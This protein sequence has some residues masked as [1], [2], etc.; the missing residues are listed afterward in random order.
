MDTLA[1]N[2]RYLLVY[3]HSYNQRGVESSHSVQGVTDTGRMVNVKLRVTDDDKSRFSKIPKVRELGRRDGKAGDS[4][5]AREDNDRGNR[6]GVVL[7]ARCTR[8]GESQG[9]TT[10]TAEWAHVISQHSDSHGPIAGIGRLSIS[11]KSGTQEVSAFFAIIYHLEHQVTVP[12]EQTDNLRFHLAKMLSSAME[13]GTS[14]GI[15]FRV[16]DKDGKVI[17]SLAR[18]FF[19]K[20]TT[21]TAESTQDA[22][23]STA[24]RF[25]DSISAE[26]DKHGDKQAVLTRLSRFSVSWQAFQH[27]MEDD[28]YNYIKTQYY[29]KDGTPKACR[30]V[31]RVK[32]ST[33]SGTVLLHRLHNMSDDGVPVPL[34]PSTLDTGSTLEPSVLYCSETSIELNPFSEPQRSAHRTSFATPDDDKAE[35]TAKGM[36]R[37]LEEQLKESGQWPF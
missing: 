11:K 8:E 3:P 35:R 10:Y 24:T 29:E 5:W 18:E 28:P 23:L 21:G 33:D 7:F 32:E 9:C 17:D 26:L 30:V 4:C 36:A 19:C 25:I 12:I 15:L 37:F 13:K 2:D 14:P 1:D 20:N 31:L 34:L 27:Y 16:I 22:G 6:E